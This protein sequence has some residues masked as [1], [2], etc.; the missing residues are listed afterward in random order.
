M[1]FAWRSGSEIKI[2]KPHVTTKSSSNRIVLVPLR[3][4]MSL[5]LARM[6]FDDTVLPIDWQAANSSID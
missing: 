5:P 4:N 1:P 3:L 6:I 2:V